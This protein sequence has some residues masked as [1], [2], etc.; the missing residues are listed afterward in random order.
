LGG[1]FWQVGRIANTSSQCCIILYSLLESWHSLLG[2]TNL[3]QM[4]RLDAVEFVRTR[5]DHSLSEARL[6]GPSAKPAPTIISG[7]RS[8]ALGDR[9]VIYR[10]VIARRPTVTI[11]PLWSIDSFAVTTS[12]PKWT[13]V[14]MLLCILMSAWVWFHQ[15]AV[16]DGSTMTFW[17]SRI[18]VHEL[19]TAV[20]LLLAVSAL[21]LFAASSRS[22]LVI[23]NQSGKNKI[24]F[25]VPRGMENPLLE[26]VAEVEAQIGRV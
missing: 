13:V 25:V 10:D 17:G 16:F 22:K 18:R 6:S 23:Y 21:G 12:R 7:T 5:A 2:V 8:L 19:I 26:F 20:F 14:L 4:D 15:P 11:L 1:K 9:Y 3:D 24:Q